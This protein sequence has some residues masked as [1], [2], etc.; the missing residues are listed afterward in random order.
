MIVREQSFDGGKA[1]ERIEGDGASTTPC[2]VRVVE[3]EWGTDQLASER[4]TRPC[5]TVWHPGFQKHAWVMRLKDRLAEV[6]D[7]FNFWTDYKSGAMGISVAGA[8]AEDLEDVLRFAGEESGADAHTWTG[9]GS[10]ALVV[11]WRDPTW[12]TTGAEVETWG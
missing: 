7:H 1:W 2:W 3:A 5:G 9:V 12:R 11:A 8:C 6:H 10:A 4:M